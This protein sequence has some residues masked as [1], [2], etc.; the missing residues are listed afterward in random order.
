[1]IM[2]PAGF[3]PAIVRPQTDALDRAVSGTQHKADIWYG[4]SKVLTDV[5]YYVTTKEQQIGFIHFDY[6]SELNFYGQNYTIVTQVLP[7]VF[8]MSC[9]VRLF[10]LYNTMLAV[11]SDRLLS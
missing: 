7:K 10:V 4:C 1:M 6:F 3:E 2:P 8:G 11:A 9:N 5:C